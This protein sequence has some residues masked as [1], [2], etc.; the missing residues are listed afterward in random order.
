MSHQERPTAPASITTVKDER[1]TPQQPNNNH[2]NTNP[3]PDTLAPLATAV[4][5]VSTQSF[6]KDP[7]CYEN[8]T[9]HKPYIGEIPTVQDK[10]LRRQDPA[11]DQHTSKTN[12]MKAG[13]SSRVNTR[14]HKEYDCY[15]NTSAYIPLALDRPNAKANIRR[16]PAH[17][18]NPAITKEKSAKTGVSP[19]TQIRPPQKYKCYANTPE[20]SPTTRQ[21]PAILSKIRRIQNPPLD[22][23]NDATDPAPHSTPEAV[24]NCDNMFLVRLGGKDN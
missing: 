16:I 7:E 9:A 1:Q 3:R 24:G 11:S 17:S 15:E 8:T 10:T 12:Q 14:L 18:F 6:L 20:Y 4:S 22:T 23:S 19:D 13:F 21:H 2:H 5:S